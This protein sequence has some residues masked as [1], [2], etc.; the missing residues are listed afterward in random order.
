MRDRRGK[1]ERE[2]KDAEIEGENER[3]KKFKGKGRKRK[4]ENLWRDKVKENMRGKNGEN[5]AKRLNRH[6][7][8]FAEIIYSNLTAHK[9][10]K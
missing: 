4:E 3:E 5:V 9:C 7:F 6:H 10:A 2:K 1:R 8:S